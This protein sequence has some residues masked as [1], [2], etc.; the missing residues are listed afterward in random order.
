[1]SGCPAFEDLNAL[2]DGDLP[3][4]REARARQHL[5]RCVA[6]RREVDGLTALKRAVGR[7]YDNEVPTPAGLPKRRRRRVG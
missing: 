4:E 1:M 7:A 2:V 3:S 6:C 5:V